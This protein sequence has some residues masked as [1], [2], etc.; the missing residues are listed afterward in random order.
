[1]DLFVEFSEKVKCSNDKGMNDE[2]NP[3][4]LFPTFQ[5][6]W[7]IVFLRVCYYFFHWTIF[8]SGAS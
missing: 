4:K 8:L 7:L 3:I 6:G 5:N 2:Y 1:L